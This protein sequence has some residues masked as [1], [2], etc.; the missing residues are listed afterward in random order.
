MTPSPAID[1]HQHLWPPELI[2]AL[3]AAAAP[4]PAWSAGR[5]CSTASRRTRSTRRPRRAASPA[6]LEAGTDRARPVQPAGYRGPPA[7]RG[8]G[9]CWPP[10]TRG[11]PR[12]RPDFDA[13]ASV[14]P[15]GPRPRR[16]RAAAGRRLRRAADPATWLADPGGGR[17]AGRRA[18]G[19][20]SGRPPGVRAPRTGRAGDRSRPTSARTGGPP[21]STTRPDAGRL[22]VLACGRPVAVPGPADL[23]RRRRRPGSRAPRA[24]TWP[25]AARPLVVDSGT[26]V[27]TSSYSRQ[28]VDSLIRVLG[29]DPI[30]VGSDRPYGRPYETDQGDAA[31]DA[32]RH[33][34]PLRLLEG[35]R[36]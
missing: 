30:V 22:V 34:N 33:T 15:A 24:V 35:T 26:F 9:R 13:W 5:C 11:R 8:R 32:F 7:G 10:G 12:L 29:V 25:G 2:D 16:P 18:G 1:I 31:A 36:T 28:G 3:R 19:G 27:D 17:P 20:R 6:R 14:Q 4:S 21:S 23:L